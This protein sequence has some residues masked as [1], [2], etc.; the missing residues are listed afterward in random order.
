MSNQLLPFSNPADA[1][2]RRS[3]NILINLLKSD[4]KKFH[5]LNW[6]EVR[7]VRNTDR[8]PFL[9]RDIL[10]TQIQDENQLNQ[11]W[12]PTSAAQRVIERYPTANDAPPSDPIGLPIDL[13][14]IP[15]SYV[16]R[17]KNK[18]TTN[19]QAKRD[20]GKQTKQQSTTKTLAITSN[21]DEE[22]TK[23]AKSA[24]LVMKA[25]LEPAKQRK[26]ALKKEEASDDENETSPNQGAPRQYEEVIKRINK[27]IKKLSKDEGDVGTYGCG[28]KQGNAP[29][30]KVLN[31]TID[32]HNLMISNRDNEEATK[33]FEKG[34]KAIQK[35]PLSAKRDAMSVKNLTTLHNLLTGIYSK[36]KEAAIA[37]GHD[38]ETMKLCE[39]WGIDLEAKAFDSDEVDEGPPPKKQRKD[40]KS[41]PKTS[42]KPTKKNDTGDE[43]AEESG[44]GAEKHEGSSEDE[45]EDDEEDDE[46]DED[47]DEEEYSSVE[48]EL[49]SPVAAAAKAKDTKATQKTIKDAPKTTKTGKAE[50]K[51]C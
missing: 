27:K 7:L 18:K 47:E 11:D 37:P 51:G 30:F 12:S 50:T 3:Q 6:E 44:K 39:E 48:E 13:N 22:P 5:T 14:N 38:E 17:K 9:T 20:Q 35:A 34:K 43:G 45:N 2:I 32:I 24:K 29:A 46:N 19:K 40:R 49:N 41:A 42:A 1:T 15:S 33:L 10:V 31:L 28:P 4:E 8:F 25:S 36:L 21:T 26:S 16:H 23:M